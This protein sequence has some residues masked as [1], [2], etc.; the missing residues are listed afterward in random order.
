MDLQIKTTSPLENSKVIGKYYIATIKT[1]PGKD[2]EVIYKEPFEALE[3]ETITDFLKRALL[4][5]NPVKEENI[6]KDTREVYYLSKRL[7]KE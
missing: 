6:D 7:I 2:D 4:S 3:N 5:F 1:M